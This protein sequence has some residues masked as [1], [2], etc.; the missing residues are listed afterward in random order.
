MPSALARL[1][2]N[3]TAVVA[4][5]LVGSL[6]SVASAIGDAAAVRIVMGV[7]AHW[8]GAY[9]ILVRPPG[10]R[11]DLERTAGVVEP[12][13]LDF[14][15]RGGIS[16]STLAAIRAV[17]GVALAAPVGLVG[18]A[19]ADASA[20]LTF[21]PPPPTE[22]TLYRLVFTVTAND[23]LDEHLVQ[24]ETDRL[25]YGRGAAEQITSDLKNI[26]IA[27]SETGDVTGGRITANVPLPALRSP[28]LAVDPAA[29]RELLGPSATFLDPLAAV[30][31]VGRTVATFGHA[32]IPDTFR[33]AQRILKFA[34][35]T[36]ED[37]G[38]T[39][40]QVNLM[41][42]RP[43]IPLIV[44]S[45][46]YADLTLRL[47]VARIGKPLDSYP[48]DPDSLHRLAAA[49]LAAGE[50]STDIGVTSLDVGAI[51]LPLQLAQLVIDWPGSPSPTQQGSQYVISPEREYA[52]R[53]VDR[54]T[55]DEVIDESA[56]TRLRFRLTPRGASEPDSVGNP[57]PGS[58]L[59][60]GKEP[61]YRNSNAYPFSLLEDFVSQGADDQPLYFAPLG[62]FD[63]STLQLPNDPLSYVP[64]GAYDPPDTELV[65]GP[66]GSELPSPVTLKPRM[67]PAGLL[68]VPPLVI[69]DI[70][71]AELLRGPAP[72]D[73]VRVRVAD[74]ADFGAAAQA[75]IEEV[76]GAIA[77]LG[78]DVDVVAGSSPQ[79][80]DIYVPEYR[81]EQS[82]PGDLGWVEQGWTT[83]GAAERVQRGLSGATVALLA[84][85]VLT[86]TISAAGLQVF[87]I[88]TRRR[89]VA[90]L[91]ANGWSRRQVLAWLLA[92]AVIGALIVAGLAAAGWLLGGHSFSA[93]AAGALIALVYL[94][95]A[96]SASILAFRSA[97]RAQV[98]SIRAGDLWSGAARGGYLGV[99][100]P[101]SY[102]LRTVAVRPVRSL[103]LVG[104]LTVTGTALAIGVVRLGTILA[105]VGPTRLASALA[106]QAEPF[107]IVLI[108]LTA[109]VGL[110]FTLATWRLDAQ[111]RA[112]ELLALR[113][114]GW[115]AGELRRARLVSALCVG[116]VA[117]GLA[118]ALTVTI[119]APMATLPIAAT[120]AAAMAACLVLALGGAIGDPRRRA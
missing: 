32:R 9:D 108:M 44:S 102:G 29:E 115:D 63:L 78:L 90:V 2:R 18:F 72:I 97:S 117:A 67:D 27:V 21:L 69:T 59:E 53:L 109:A 39:A 60:L 66:D 92:E 76:A 3:R 85:T 89:E 96:A 31:D 119:A 74:V 103:A 62:E 35:S 83:L 49:E 71:S 64:F 46:A 70:A 58:A 22:P 106:G 73:A 47:T 1:W 79:Q 52:A 105:E 112:G 111:D 14:G 30:A 81:V 104:G 8:R 45:T 86:A 40:E 33:P 50:G 88:A 16:V 25:L 51:L 80:V 120:V 20:P 43:V 75:R 107:Q 7:D 77:A 12:N 100:G 23:G 4:I 82:P 55:Y 61:I 11:L 57:T 65:A 95:T 98:S 17:D 48:P 36:E 91:R 116:V 38:T 10:A 68:T 93:A 6:A 42:G 26:D 118:A 113:A 56:P 24:R 54:P 87:A 84:L 15:G 5:V 41:L 34:E 94:A 37:P 114:L 13:F 99:R 19:R 28:I 110:A 101:I